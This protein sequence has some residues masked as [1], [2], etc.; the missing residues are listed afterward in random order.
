MR[1]HAPPHVQVK[2]AGGVRTLDTLLEYRAVGVTRAGATRTVDILEECKRRL[3]GAEGYASANNEV[4]DEV[5]DDEPQ[6][7][8]ATIPGYDGGRDRRTGG[9][10]TVCGARSGPSGAERDRQSALIGCGARG[11]GQVMPSFL[12]LP[13]VRIVAVCDVNSKHLASADRRPVAIRWRPTAI[14]ASCWT[15]SRSTP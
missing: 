11:A 13:G 12:K 1:Q 10:T 6:D 9:R 3:H 14:T 4:R 2:A 7:D 5:R 8:A 15:T